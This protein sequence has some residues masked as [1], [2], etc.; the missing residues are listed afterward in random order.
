MPPRRLL[1][2]S[3]VLLGLL[4]GPAW[5]QDDT[6]NDKTLGLKAPVGSII[7]FDGEELAGW[8]HR[9][10]K[11]ASWPVTGPVF[12]VAGGKG[13][14]RTQAEFGNYKLHLE[15]ACP[16][17]PEAKGQARGNSGVYI[18]GVHEVQ[19]LDSYGLKSQS[20]DCAGIYQQHAPRVN[21]CKPPLQWQT[22]DIT[23]HKAKVKDGQV[24]KKAR[25][26]VVHNGV[27][28]ID[29]KEISPTPGG[30]GMEPGKNGPLLLQDHGNAVQY[31]N[32]WLVPLPED[33][34]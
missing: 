6:P 5:A 9:D 31:R 30:L 4:R 32:I 14:I 1:S 10:G 13:D 11:P 3:L 2:L 7:L 27:N 26:T 25:I 12:T 29:D 34:E 24:V 28:V 22:Y 23:F 21:A 20:N 17:M 16:L 15:F 19:V 33:D 8:T 18:G